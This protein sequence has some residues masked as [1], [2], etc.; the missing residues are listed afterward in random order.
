MRLA[1]RAHMLGFRGHFS[2]KGRT[3]STTFGALRAL[4]KSNP[5]RKYWNVSALLRPVGRD[6]PQHRRE[7]MPGN[8][9]PVRPGGVLPR[10]SPISNTTA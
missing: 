2:T 8:T 1:A 9:N 5:G 10:V 6:R 7:R 4:A 3:Y